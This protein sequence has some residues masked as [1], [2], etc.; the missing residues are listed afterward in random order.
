M[1]KGKAPQ[2]AQAGRQRDDRREGGV[3]LGLVGAKLISRLERSTQIRDCRCRA[4]AIVFP[5]GPFRHGP[6]SAGQCG[7]LVPVQ[8]AD[9][10][11][12]RYPWNAISCEFAHWVIRQCRLVAASCAV[13]MRSKLEKCEGRAGFH[14]RL[15]PLA[16]GSGA[17]A[18]DKALRGRNMSAARS[19]A[20][21]RSDRIGGLACP[22]RSQLQCAKSIFPRVLTVSDDSNFVCYTTWRHHAFDAS[23]RLDVWT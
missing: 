20:Q 9:D 17:S 3:H 23:T 7:L 22:C 19:P 1:G 18:E 8:Q 15:Q 13:V 21:G 10:P 12:S 11:A 14:C 4:L 16:R 5:S 2:E 6:S